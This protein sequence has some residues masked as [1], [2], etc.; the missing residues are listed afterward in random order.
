MAAAVL[1][2]LIAAIFPCIHAEPA[3]P[4]V[5]S[6]T[7][8][9]VWAIAIIVVFFVAVSAVLGTF[10]FKRRLRL[11]R[12]STAQEKSTPP[13]PSQ[14]S[15]PPRDEST[16][17]SHIDI[18]KPSSSYKEICISLPYPP[19]STFL[20]SDKLELGSNDDA[21]ALYQ[22]YMNSNDAAVTSNPNNGKRASVAAT[23]KNTL[24]QSLRL[25]KSSKT[26]LSHVAFDPPPSTTGKQQDHQS[27][28]NNTRR[29][30]TRRSLSIKK[31]STTTLSPDSKLECSN[32]SCSSP[33][34]SD[35]DQSTL[36][37]KSRSMDSDHV[38]VAESRPIVP[39]ISDQYE[40][41]TIPSPP[42][43]CHY[44]TPASPTCSTT[45]SSAL[46]SIEK[47]GATAEITAH[48][49]IQYASVRTKHRADQR[50]SALD[51]FASP[52]QQQENPF[53]SVHDNP[54]RHDTMARRQRE[55]KKSIDGL[56]GSD[57]HESQ[58]T[59]TPPPPP[60]PIKEY[61]N[62]TNTTTTTTT[63][64]IDPSL[65]AKCELPDDDD[66]DIRPDNHA[67][68]STTITDIPQCRVSAELSAMNIF[69]ENDSS[70]SSQEEEYDH[71]EPIHNNN[72][73]NQQQQQQSPTLD[74]DNETK[75]ISPAVSST[76]HTDKATPETKS[77]P[78]NG[79]VQDIIHWWQKESSLRSSNS[80]QSISSTTQKSPAPSSSLS[81]S[82]HGTL[83]KP[84]PST[85]EPSTVRSNRNSILGTPRATPPA[86]MRIGNHAATGTTSPRASLGSLSRTSAAERMKILANSSISSNTSHVDSLRK[87]LQ[88]TAW[89]TSSNSPTH[90]N[91]SSANSSLRCDPPTGL[92]SLSAR[93]QQSYRPAMPFMGEEDFEAPVPTASFSSSTVRTMI[94]ADE[95]IGPGGGASIV[96]T[97]PSTNT[98]SNNG[99]FSRNN[100]IN[101]RQQAKPVPS[102]PNHASVRSSS[103][104][105]EDASSPKRENTQAYTTVRGG[106]RTRGSI[107]WLPEST[108]TP[109]TTDKKTP[110]QKE[111][112]R[113]L[114]SLK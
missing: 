25:Q 71:S 98:S 33:V 23:L 104:S 109:T 17:A 10:F 43:P 88:T 114:K 1:L 54:I 46:P 2:L 75:G 45:P 72:N 13:H 77:L 80:E 95:Y 65:D 21:A 63:T 51:C 100:P 49:V 73:N 113:Y 76:Q 59:T 47:E 35:N 82:T 67:M 102:K 90:S 92:V 4:D 29:L 15:S 74:K 81:Q 70:D 32:I 68:H 16:L 66:E 87:K 20:F 50:K 6:R 91:N 18:E 83:G 40:R 30:S 11:G 110:A 24:R 12:S 85:S 111:R 38:V 36:Q 56:F 97:A 58:S 93:A 106:K 78:R 53:A 99:S 26:P 37:S 60:P 7:S 107:P 103:P 108:A 39:R 48:Q 44:P 112:D 89:P 28:T 14:S 9:P 19:Q 5:S 105:K 84:T 57:M 96:D 86:S 8:L 22:K 3:A 27:S 64:H 61:D 79:S 55:N 101:Q 52:L 41:P 94:P 62:T 69:S 42:P 34:F 31:K